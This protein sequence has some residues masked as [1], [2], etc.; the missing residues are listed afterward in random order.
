MEAEISYEILVTTYGTGRDNHGINIEMQALP[1]KSIVL[2]KKIWI[3]QL[4]EQ[5]FYWFCNSG[6][7]RMQMVF[8]RTAFTTFFTKAAAQISNFMQSESVIC[9]SHL[10]QDAAISGQGVIIQFSLFDACGYLSDRQSA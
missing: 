3:D 10:D 2:V 9:Q 8:P 6:R 4:E 5:Q 1:V 7:R